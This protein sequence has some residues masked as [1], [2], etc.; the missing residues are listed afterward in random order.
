GIEDPD[1]IAERVL[2]PLVRAALANTLRDGRAALTGPVAR[3]DSATLA[4]HLDALAGVDP[5]L[6]E[7]YRSNALRT[8]HRADAADDVLTVLAR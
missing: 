8:A 1:G 2:G 6:A 5:E 4:R 7:A 3:G